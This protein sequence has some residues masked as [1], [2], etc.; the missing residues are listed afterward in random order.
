MTLIAALAG[1][2]V[3]GPALAYEFPLQYTPG[4]G[5]QGLI[6]AGYSFNASTVVGN[7]S[8]HVTTSGSGR[9]GGYHHYTVYYNHTCTWDLRGNLLTTV[10][11]AP[12]APTPIS[13]VNGITIYAKDAKGD[14]TGVDANLHIGFVNS[15]SAQ[16]AFTTPSGGYLFL[17]NQQ[18]V[19]IT[20]QIQSTGDIPLKMS[21]ISSYSTAK[22]TIAS[23]TCKPTGGVVPGASC[24]L[25]LKY[26]PSAIP[27]G[28]DPY[29]LYDHIS[30]SLV[31]N[32]GIAQA[33]TETVE[34]PI[35]PN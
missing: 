16:Y 21:S 14:T 8:Y 4:P 15:K 26:D 2:A 23:T 9:G 17:S 6:V 35:A 33:F 1:F 28:D 7:C 25:V 19:N 18:P 12:T 3:A 30:V 29:T 24:T 10:D 5:A 22:I 27:G 34:V 32:A 13:S 20:L 31:S 11:G